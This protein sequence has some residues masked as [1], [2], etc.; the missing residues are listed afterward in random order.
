MGRQRSAK[1]LFLG[2]NPGAASITTMSFYHFTKIVIGLAFKILYPLKVKGSENFPK[3]G[4]VILVANHCSYFDPLYLAVAIP[5]KINWMVLRPYY[6]LWWL[7]WLFK[8]VNSVPVNIKG[9]N[10]EA[11]KHGLRIL[12]QGKVL[13]IFPEGNRSKNG[14]LKEGES[15]VALLALKSGAPIFPVAIR[16]AFEVFPPHATL[17]HAFRRVKVQ[18]GSLLHLAI[19]KEP[20]NKETLRIITE[21]IM[22][23]I[24]K[25]MEE[26]EEKK[27]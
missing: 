2:S 19:N 16:G 13:G 27:G 4:A 8:S 11:I 10:I 6:D 3:K 20:I 9:P 1:P 24:E 7:R 5:R 14:R 18:L 23:S 15:G 25:L 12:K 21:Q 22:K 17:P 26:S